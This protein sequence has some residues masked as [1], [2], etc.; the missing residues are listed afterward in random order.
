MEST[1][2]D[3]PLDVPALD[4]DEWLEHHARVFARHADALPDAVLSVTA[5]R[6]VTRSGFLLRRSDGKLD[7]DWNVLGTT[8]LDDPDEVWRRAVPLAKRGASCY[9]GVAPRLAGTKGQ[10]GKKDVAAHVALVADLDWA[11]GDHQS[12]SNPPREVLEQWIA[13]LPVVPGLIVNSAGGYHVWVTLKEPVDVQHTDEGIALYAG[14]AHWWKERAKRDGYSI[15]LAPLNNQALVLRIAGTPAPKYPGALVRIERSIPTTD[16]DY[17]LTTLMEAYPAPP[18]EPKRS[19]RSVAGGTGRAVT[20]PKSAVPVGASLDDHTPGDVFAV[21]GDAEELLLALF[22]AEYA[23]SG[24]DASSLLLPWFGNGDPEYPPGKN[25][26]LFVHHDGTAL[27]SIYGQGV[28]EEWAAR[29]GT[30]PDQNSE[31]DLYNA[32]YILA[33][34]VARL[35]AE[36]QEAWSLAAR[37]VTHY[38]TVEDRFADYGN[39][40]PDVSVCETVEDI[41]S[42]LPA[43]ER[44][45]APPRL[46][47]PSVTW[48]IADYG[49]PESVAS[50][51]RD[52]YVAPL[53]AAARGYRSVDDPKAFA[54]DVLDLTAS[55]AR[56]FAAKIAPGTLATPW[57]DLSDETPSLRWEVGDWD[58][59]KG[60]ILAPHHSLFPEWDDVPILIEYGTLAADRSLTALLLA[61]GHRPEELAKTDDADNRLR[62]MVDSIPENRRISIVALGLGAWV[63]APWSTLSPKG[64]TIWLSD[65]EVDTDLGWQRIRR[66]WTL[67]R[68]AG[69]DV[70]LAPTFADDLDAALD[71]ATTRFPDRPRFEWW[72]AQNSASAAV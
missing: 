65:A 56:T 63:D 39:L 5:N 49:L 2:T 51:L 46:N 18:E 35:G 19:A 64:R 29:F 57:C 41:E 1:V 61:E 68:N 53:V 13:D 17:D 10:G 9:V 11:E 60:A 45:S 59:G 47:P 15:D 67:L 26:G 32:F 71:A 27:L 48:D 66:I 4:R 33:Q 40:I 70:A 12:A 22:D 16:E 72:D 21:E 8:A 7:L 55:R 34:Y 3:I 23:G 37:L 14:F 25:A 20:T 36:P 24:V 44:V 6:P 69:A 30:V 42:L 28:R 54:R 52:A 31:L 38:R 58:S 62:W 50:I 43:R